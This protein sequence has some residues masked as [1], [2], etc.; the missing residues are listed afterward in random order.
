MFQTRRVARTEGA[1]FRVSNRAPWSPA[2]IVLAIVGL[3]FIVIGGVGLA[4]AGIHFNTIPFTRTQ[5]AG[6]GFTCMSALIQLVAGVFMLVG[7]I[8]PTMA[9]STMWFFGVLLIAFGLIVAIGTTSFTT[10]WGYR[11]AN[12]VF[13]VVAGAVLVLAAALSPIFYSRHQVV[14]REVLQ[15]DQAPVVEAVGRGPVGQSV[16][17][18][19]RTVRL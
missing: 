18:E 2:Q 12:G 7:S 10:M 15:D 17:R 3:V 9:K 16:Y 11:T 5:V 14:S 4:R 8:E 13:D 6:L 1:S 19:D